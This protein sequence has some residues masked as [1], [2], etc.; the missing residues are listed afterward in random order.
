MI[1]RA[2]RT[3]VNKLVAVSVFGLL[4][5]LTARVDELAR[6]EAI[7]AVAAPAFLLCLLM[8]WLTCLFVGF[9]LLLLPSAGGVGLAMREAGSS[10]FTLGFSYPPEPGAS[11]IVFVAAASG[12]AVLALLI[13]YLPLLYTAFDRRDTLVAILEALAGAPPWGPELLARQALID[14]SAT[15][16]WLYRRWTE[17]AADISESHVNLR[18]PV[19]F[20]FPR[21]TA[22]WLHSLLS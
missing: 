6:R 1:P 7:L 16:P 13:S 11:A 22:S 4:R 20:R 2:T 10:L 17:G 21:P 18:T 5:L 3:R 12:L 8:T 19:Y 9:S 15:L 14:N